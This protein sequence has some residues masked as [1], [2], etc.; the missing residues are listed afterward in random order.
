MSV[1]IAMLTVEE[2]FSIDD[3]VS[4]IYTTNTTTDHNLN[5]WF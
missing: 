5:W 1:S 2:Q 3:G 4:D